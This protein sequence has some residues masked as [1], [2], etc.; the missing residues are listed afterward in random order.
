MKFGEFGHGVGF[1]LLLTLSKL[2]LIAQLVKNPPA[3]QG[4]LVRFLCSFG[5][6]CGSAG[7]E[8][9]CSVRDLGSIPALG[10]RERLPTLV[11]WPRELNG[12]YSPWG[13]EESDTTE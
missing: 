7:K 13:R 11:F 1:E 6:P 2:S 3:T 4:T 8:S 5:F 10:R 9:A 12:L